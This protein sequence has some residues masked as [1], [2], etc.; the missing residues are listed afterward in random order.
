MQIAFVATLCIACVVDDFDDP[1]SKSTARSVRSTVAAGADGDSDETGGH[2][3]PWLC[4]PILT[5][6]LLGRPAEAAASKVDLV[7]T[8]RPSGLSVPLMRGREPPKLLS[9]P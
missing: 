5:P 6:D 7:I 8:P 2:E 3:A 9:R 4:E 1:Q